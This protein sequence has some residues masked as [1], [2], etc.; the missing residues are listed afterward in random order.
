MIIT[1]AIIL[2][3]LAILDAIKDTLYSHFS[4]SIFSQ[5]NPKF[6]KSLESWKYAKRIPILDYPIDAW[7]ICKSLMLWL[8]FIPFTLVLAPMWQ[9]V[10]TD[11]N[12][13]LIWLIIGTTYTL[14]FNLFY[15]FLLIRKK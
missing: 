5:L 11:W 10:S 6:W 4:R 13:V 1:I 9:I 2:I 3:V 7:H 14:I 12:Y 8:I 15:N